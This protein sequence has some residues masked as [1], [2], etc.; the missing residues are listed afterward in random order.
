MFDLRKHLKAT[1]IINAILIVIV[2]IFGI[3]LLCSDKFDVMA[4]FS[5]PFDMVTLAIGL[6]YALKGYQK[7][8]A[9]Y[10]KF[11]MVCGALSYFISLVCAF[12]G[13]PNSTARI[14]GLIPL[15]INIIL[16][17]ILAF[18]KDFGRTK[19]I[20]VAVA[21][22]ALN[23]FLL[24]MFAIREE[25]SGS[26]FPIVINISQLIVISIITCVFVQ[27]KFLEKSYRGH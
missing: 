24:I 16:M 22:F 11:F 25:V 14:I 20:L 6:V 9:N 23:V 17:I 15:I 27:A 19:S 26:S 12:Q 5:I 13:N 1:G 8:A 3:V 2:M 10:Y 7:A 18:A 21:T 4:K